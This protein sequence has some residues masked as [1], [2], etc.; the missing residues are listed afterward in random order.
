[1]VPA[2]G[3]TRRRR[4]GAREGE[5]ARADLDGGVR[6]ADALRLPERV[7][8]AEPPLGLDLG[9]PLLLLPGAEPVVDEEV[10]VEPR[11]VGRDVA[12]PGR[13]V[14]AADALEHV[15][16]RHAEELDA[17]HL[18]A[19]DAGRGGR[20]NARADDARPARELRRLGRARRRRAE[21][22]AHPHEL[23]DA[24]ELGVR[25][26]LG[27]LG[28]LDE[29]RGDDDVLAGR[30]HVLAEL[31]DDSRAL[32]DRHELLDARLLL[33]ARQEPLR[34]LGPARRGPGADARDVGR[35]VRRL[36]VV[37]L[38]AV[39][40]AVL[41]AAGR[42][43]ALAPGGAALAHLARRALVGRLAAADDAALALGAGPGRRSIVVAGCRSGGRAALGFAR[44]GAR[45]VPG[46]LGVLARAL[47]LARRH[48]Q[49]RA[50]V[51]HGRRR[52]LGL[53]HLAA[54][55]V[56]RAAGAEDLV[57]DVLAERERRADLLAVVA[58]GRGHDDVSF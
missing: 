8:D 55:A 33:H 43:E 5:D 26:V 49:R 48:A 22:D 9:P 56:A 39:V 45:G 29:R 11:R 57:A 12:R 7:G 34:G 35:R 20:D 3:R 58:C 41:A 32:G 44:A 50:D 47:A 21:R 51:G 54:V 53:R 10:A 40:A 15:L 28:G 25:E 17:V 30:G 16:L 4:A 2:A 19:R 6:L 13:H 24:R 1:M 18:V 31:V 27:D 37:R 46:D 36:L 14:L 52:R 42:R 38:L 23:A